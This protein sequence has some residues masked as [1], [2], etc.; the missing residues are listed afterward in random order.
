MYS[1]FYDCAKHLLHL[2]DFFF[3]P[4]SDLCVM[5]WNW[6]WMFSFW[7]MTLASLL[8]QRSLLPFGKSWGYIWAQSAFDIIFSEFFVSSAFL[9][10]R[11][12]LTFT[13][14]KV[15]AFGLFMFTVFNL[16]WWFCKFSLCA[17]SC[18]LFSLFLD[19]NTSQITR[20]KQEMRFKLCVMRWKTIS[21]NTQ[22]RSRGL[23][24]V[25][26]QLPDIRQQQCSFVQLNS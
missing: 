14:Y 23:F 9:I 4:F 10:T 13:Y 5:C 11:C 20:V 16:L 26:W 24:W 2:R 7:W 8:A 3:I 6:S 18:R 12:A 15:F 25:G 21:E 17:C 19:C 1:F 22:P